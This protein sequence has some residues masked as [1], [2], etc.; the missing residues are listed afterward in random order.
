MLPVTPLRCISMTNKECKVRLE[1]INVNIDEPVIFPFSIKTSKRSG[2]CNNINH[3]Y[4]KMCGPDVVKNLK[5][6]KC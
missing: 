3:P 4:T 5:M 6:L 1:I 2:N